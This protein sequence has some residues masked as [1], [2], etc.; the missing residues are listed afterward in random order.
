[1][2]FAIHK[3][4]SANSD[5]TDELFSDHFINRTDRFFMLIYLIFT[6]MLTH[7]V[8]CC[9]IRVIIIYYMIPVPKDKRASKSDSNNYRAIAIWVVF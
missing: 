9:T 5:C 2:I 4:K 6:Y 8:R 1:M 7:G 3:L